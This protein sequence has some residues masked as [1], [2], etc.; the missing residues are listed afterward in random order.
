MTETVSLFVLATNNAW[1]LTYIAVG[2]S[3][4]GTDPTGADGSAVSMT[5]TSP[6]VEVPRYPLAGTAVP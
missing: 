2:C 4:T 6:V 3:W 5:L 1:P